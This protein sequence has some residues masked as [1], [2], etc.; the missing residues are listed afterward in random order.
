V[1]ESL[2]ALEDQYFYF[3][4]TLADLTDEDAPAPVLEALRKAVVQSRTNYW[5][6][7]HKILHDDDPEVAALVEQMEAAQCA[8]DAAVKNLN[9]VAKILTAVTKAIDIGSEL[10]AKAVAL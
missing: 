9:N 3:M 4:Q 7:I 5:K 6:A 8:I 10:A 2:Q 1:N